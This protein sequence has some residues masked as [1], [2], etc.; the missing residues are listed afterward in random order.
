[1]FKFHNEYVPFFFHIK[2]P[3]D[4]SDGVRLCFALSVLRLS[5]R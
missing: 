3:P 2:T 4:L 1:M 5:L